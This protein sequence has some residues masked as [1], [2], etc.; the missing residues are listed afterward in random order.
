MF[1]DEHLYSIA[2]RRCSLIGDINFFKLVRDAGSAE[3]V[4]RSAKKLLSKTDGIGSRTVSD[5][6][7]PEHLKF[8]E[9]ELNFCRKNNIT[10]LLRHQNELPKLL[11]ECEDAPAVLYCKGNIPAEKMPVSMVG[12]RNITDYGKAFISDFFSSVK[13]TRCTS[14]SGLA[15]GVDTLVHE[16]SVKNNIPTLAIL[17]HGFHTLYP[18]KNRK[19]SEKI[20]ENGGALLTEFNSSQK[21]DRENFIQRNR[22]IAGISAATVV[23]ESAFGG[24]SISTVTFANDYNRD[25]YALPGKITDKYS[26]GCNRLI[27]QNKASSIVTVK[28]LINELGYGTKQ[29]PTEELFPRSETRTVLT[30]EQQM[31]YNIILDRPAV[32]LD[33]IADGSGIPSHKLFSVLL[34]LELSGYIQTLSGRQYKVV[35][36]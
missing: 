13:N 36:H 11:H 6:G 35:K 29:E 2:L 27:A 34:D 31:V 23:V 1:S 18:S 16:E 30:E 32:S 5:I 28:D 26:Q 25:V 33:D 10:I 8:A 12:T 19:L 4:W 21:P 15:L 17:A 14:V 9:S 20:L 3:K 22:V 24:G 7:N